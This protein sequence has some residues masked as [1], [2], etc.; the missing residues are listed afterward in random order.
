MLRKGCEHL[1]L[2]SICVVAPSPESR[3]G[4]SS[5]VLAGA[6]SRLL[7]YTDVAGEEHCSSVNVFDGWSIHG[8]DR[9][10]S[11]Y[12]DV[13]T[14]YGHKEVAVV[15]TRELLGRTT[16]ALPA[17]LR[18]FSGLDDLVLDCKVVSGQDDGEDGS[19]ADAG[20]PLPPP[21]ILA[22]GYAHNMV[23]VCV[24]DDSGR[25]TR[26]SRTVSPMTCLLFSMRL[27]PLAAS[28]VV[29]SGTAYGDIIM[30]SVD[31][32]DTTRNDSESEGKA[33]GGWRECARPT[34]TNRGLMRGHEGVVTR[35]AF[36]TLAGGDGGGEAACF[37]A[38]ASDDRSMRLWD[39]TRQ[40]S[41]AWRD[42]QQQLQTNTLTES[43]T[44]SSSPPP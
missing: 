11:S 9:A 40:V 30:W 38:S 44:S 1:P 2:T 6:G 3:T 34:M 5:A 23:D 24:V 35:V 16:E 21:V 42:G 17:S 12:R 4:G 26:R 19:G 41:E 7:I 13:V 27:L 28:L 25:L 37:L 29:A 33:G 31:D 18:V 22:I 36:Q 14:L 8:I 20:T 10:F 39:V 32:D 43:S 15:Q